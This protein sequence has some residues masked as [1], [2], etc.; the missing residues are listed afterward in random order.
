[1]KTLT[2]ASAVVFERKI[3]LHIS[4]YFSMLTFQPPPPFGAPAV[5]RG[6]QFNSLKCTPSDDSIEVLHIVAF[7]F[8]K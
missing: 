1:M 4:L 6:S 8:L 5:V 7:L 2:F 3:F